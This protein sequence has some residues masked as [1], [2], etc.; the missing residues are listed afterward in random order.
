MKKTLTAII[1][2]STFLF[3][4]T[5]E[6][7]KKYFDEKKFNEA[8]KVF[9]EL[10][11]VGDTNPDLDFYLGRSAFQVGE[12]KE[13]LFAFE[14]VLIEAEDQKKINR[15]KLE[16]A[17]THQ[18]L[19]EKESA[20]ALLNEVLMSNPPKPVQINIKKLLSSL[21]KKEEKALSVSLFAQILG[22]YEENVNSQPDIEDLRDFQGIS[23]LDS[24]SVDSSFVATT[25][26]LFSNYKLSEIFAIQGSVFGYFQKYSE[27]ED[28]DI[29]S[30]SA[31]VSPVLFIDGYKFE[32]PMRYSTVTYGGE[33]LLSSFTYGVKASTSLSKQLGASVFANLKV[34]DMENET[35]SI[36]DSMTTQL[37]ISLNINSKS[38]S[39]FLRISIDDEVSDDDLAK[40]TDL[41]NKT[42]YTLQAKDTL[43]SVVEKIDISGLYTFRYTD[44]ENY[45]AQK[46]ASTTDGTAT[47]TQH[48]FGVD[49]KRE[50]MK[51]VTLSL[52][53]K[54]IINDSNNV[55]FE[56][57][58]YIFNFGLE[59]LY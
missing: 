24:D 45:I 44:Y 51:N 52:S 39:G 21:E 34:K 35:T 5:F 26:A 57:S 29:S 14:R 19:G 37:G 38:N 46:D 50:M 6:E 30:V 23:D 25:I 53:G 12:F 33:D 20:K 47:V 11:K 16:L 4:S 18:Q 58:K 41:T 9:S 43:K 15:T 22:G 42:I 32:M 1:L 56:Y 54:Y 55:P 59:Y 40:S 27:D 8:F 48:T 3:S 10:S 17:R 7:G 28:Y 36:D 31:Q 2:F 49:V 13:A